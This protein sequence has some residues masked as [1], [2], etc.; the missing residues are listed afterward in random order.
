MELMFRYMYTTVPERPRS[1]SMSAPLA[2]YGYGLPV[3][4]LYARYFQGDLMLSS[5]EGYGTD[6]YIYL[7]VGGA[8]NSGGDWR[9]L[10]W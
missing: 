9:W 6:A 2:G 3:S 10:W 8:L 7:K 4:R 1:D 5:L